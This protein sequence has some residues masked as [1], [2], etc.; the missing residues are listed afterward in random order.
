M[1]SQVAKA[2]ALMFEKLGD[3]STVQKKVYVVE[4]DWFTLTEITDPREQGKFFAES[5][6]VISLISPQWKFYITWV[7]PGGLDDELAKVSEG[8]VNLTNNVLTTHETR[9]RVKKGHEDEGLLAFFPDGFTIL[10]EARIPIDEWYAKVEQNG[11]MFRVQAPF[12]DGARAIEQNE[13]NS[14]YLNSG[15]AFCV[16]K[17]D[18]GFVWSGAGA[19][20]EETAAAQKLFDTV[21]RPA[22]ISTMKEGEESAEFWE[23][24]GGQG[25]YSRIKQAVGIV[26]NDFEPRLFNVSNRSG[27]MWMEEIPAFGQEDLINDDCYVLDAYNTIFVW[28]GHLSNKFEKKGVYTKAKKYRDEL[29]D[30]DPKEVMLEEVSAGYEPPAFTVQ[31]IQW[32]PEVA[33]KW[34]ATDPTVVAA[35]LAEETKAAAQAA[36]DADPFEG[37][38]DPKTNKFPYEELKGIFPK[39]VKPNMKEYYLS[40]EEF[41]S[42]LG[43]DHAA[44]GELKKWKQEKKKKEVG[45]F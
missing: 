18:A 33:A 5:V 17:G 11:V 30:R 38:L 26:P 24:V 35:A 7:G 13:C 42:V 20:D 2:K 23:S 28:I 15:D 9:T 43:M 44:W 34:I 29:Q 10:D 39:G 40:D 6:Y 27:Y 12:G 37:F 19:D 45:L 25:E 1:A 3:I 4:S 41:A 22:A 21:R 14:K 16:I 32:E 36:L 8:I 31:F